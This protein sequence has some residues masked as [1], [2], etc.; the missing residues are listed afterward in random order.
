VGNSL[1]TIVVDDSDT[2]RGELVKYLK[3][4][5]G[6]DVIAE[7]RG[8]LEAISLAHLHPDLDLVLM[9]VSMPGMGGL[10][11]AKIIKEHLGS[12][13]I[14]LVTIHDEETYRRLADVVQVDGFVCKSSVKNDL[15]VVLG[16]IRE[17][18]KGS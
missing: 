6:I 5:S 14:V 9:D 17:D 7:A 10:E 11:A 1:S 2:Y 12:V 3:T 8:G 18:L 16:R 13:K 15:P 4:Q